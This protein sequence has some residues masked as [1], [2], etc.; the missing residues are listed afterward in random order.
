MN[1]STIKYNVLSRK[2]IKL[3]GETKMFLNRSSKRTKSEDLDLV[4][5]SQE[6]RHKEGSC[7][8]EGT[9]FDEE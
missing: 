9:A 3:S 7:L 8:G 2:D 5:Y 1:N 6:M 4:D